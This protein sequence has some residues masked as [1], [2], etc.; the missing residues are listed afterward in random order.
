MKEMRLRL[1]MALMNMPKLWSRFSKK[2]RMLGVLV[3][4]LCY[5]VLLDWW[6]ITPYTKAQ[7]ADQSTVLTLSNEI[8]S[9]QKQKQT[10]EQ[11]MQEERQSVL[12]KKRQILLEEQSRLAQLLASNNTIATQSIGTVVA[13][14]EASL[15]KELK[16]QIKALAVGEEL[17][18][19]LPEGIEKMVLQV[20][21]TGSWEG[22]VKAQ[23]ILYATPYLGQIG[24]IELRY[25][26]GEHYAKWTFEVLLVDTKI[27]LNPQEVK[28]DKRG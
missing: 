21:L 26:D 19:D 3:L 8:E 2:E 1:N 13:Q 4:L 10:I 17:K 15:P 23:S 22:L 12:A 18:K 28:K 14:L 25:Q 5:A 20:Q 24:D 27:L 16:I 6:F 11:Q 9:L 7:Q